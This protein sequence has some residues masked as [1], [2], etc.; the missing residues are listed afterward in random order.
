M[1]HLEIGN[2]KYPFIV[3]ANTAKNYFSKGEVA[4]DSMSDGIDMQLDLIYS[5]LVDGSLNLSWLER[6]VTKRL[7]SKK[8]LGRMVT[9]A[10]MNKAVSLIFPTSDK[11]GKG[12]NDD[13]KK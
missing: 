10:E 5:G 2:K 1:D 4:T 3:S 8:R 6:N 12:D 11:E 13:E 9:I 7:P